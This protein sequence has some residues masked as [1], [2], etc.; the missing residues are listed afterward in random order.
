[1]KQGIART[2]ISFG[3]LS[4]SLVANAQLIEVETPPSEESS[5][6][7]VETK[8]AA[9]EALLEASAPAAAQAAP[10]AE[11]KTQPVAV[12]SSLVPTTAV[13]A[14]PMAAAPAQLSQTQSQQSLAPVS[15]TQ[16][17][18]LQP[19][20]APALNL[21]APMPTAGNANSNSGS[22]QQIIIV[23]SLSASQATAQE[24]TQSQGDPL[25]DMRMDRARREGFNDGLLLR[26]L[27]EGRISDEKERTKSVDAFSGAVS[28]G[29]SAGAAASAGASLETVPVGEPQASTASASAMAVA[30]VGGVSTS[31]SG[32]GSGVEFKVSPFLGRAWYENNRAQ[33]KVDNDFVGGVQLE[34][35]LTDYFAIEGTFAYG[36]DSFV[37]N[38]GYQQ[39]GYNGYGSYQGPYAYQSNGYY[40]GGLIPM[41][42]ARDTF[43]ASV[44]GKVGTNLGKVRPYA[45]AGIGGL[46]Q[47]Y[48]IDQVQD[49]AYLQQVGLQRS[50]N[51]LL[52]NVG[53][54]LDF[55]LG[56]NASVGGRFDYQSLLNTKPTIYNQIW[57]DSLNRMRLTGNVSV[58]F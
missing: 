11:L 30:S 5:A 6:A 13:P 45:A 41:P 23:P 31:A 53:A 19:A 32:N 4:L 21:P 34:G 50:T 58:I 29:V 49:I 56:K 55:R 14:A 22:G 3:A 57:G 36:R 8:T 18:S 9:P 52:G 35:A 54:G 42:N 27:E 47:R 12:S 10:A 51:Y 1:M 20:A 28:S 24:A 16:S 40:A 38:M 33:Y 39:Y 7:A 26:R 25:A 2:F 46:F 17:Q 44:G 15:Q 43:E 37:P 48:R